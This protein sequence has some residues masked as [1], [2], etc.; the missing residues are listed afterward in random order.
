MRLLVKKSDSVKVVVYCWEVD[1]E[2]NASHLKSEVP[3]GVTDTEEVEF[4]L[5]KPN[6]ADSNSIIRMADF[7][8]DG[9]DTKMNV[10]SF[11]ESILK[12][13]LCGWTLKNDDGNRI[14]VNSANINMLDPNVARA[15]VSGALEKIR[16]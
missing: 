5:R 1:S 3:S 15:A 16:I 14:P 12:T 2:V 9:E 6:Y 8:T 4:E 10:S 11:Q 7:K 13:L